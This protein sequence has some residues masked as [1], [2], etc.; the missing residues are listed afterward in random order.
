MDSPPLSVIVPNYNHARYLKERLDSVLGQTFS[1][2]ELIYLDDASKDNSDAV[3]ESYLAEPRLTQVV[4]NSVNSGS[5]FAQWNRGVAL[6]RGTYVWIAE[7]DDC[8]APT[9]LERLKSILDSRPNIGIAYCQSDLIDEN[10][11]RFGSA[12]DYN[13][14]LR[15]EA[16][17]WASDFTLSGSEAVAR[18]FA[19]QCVI[20]NASAVLFRRQVFLEAGGA[21]ETLRLAGDYLLWIRMLLRSDLAFVAEPLNGFRRHPG[22]VRQTAYHDGTMLRENY[23]VQSILRE[24]VSVPTETAEAACDDLMDRWIEHTVLAPGRLSPRTIRELY[25]WQRRVD[26]ASGPRFLRRLATRTGKKLGSLLGRR[27]R[28]GENQS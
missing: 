14:N 18:L 1:D 26:P 4:K 8:A 22:T 5:P 20:P 2:F 11:E 10:G 15:A 12:Y 27:E 28:A 17:L 21:D 6:A 25:R 19:R 7:A 13:R 9:F 24:S 23:L 3:L 16:E